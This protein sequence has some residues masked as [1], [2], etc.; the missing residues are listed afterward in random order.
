MSSRFYIYDI[1]TMLNC[2]LYAGKFV[3]D[4]TV[5]LFEISD[6]KN[7]R[8]ALLVHLSYLQNCGAVMVGY[9]S[10]TFDYRVVHDLLVNPYTF[11]AQ[12]AYNLAQEIIHSREGYGSQ[13]MRMS[14]RIIPQIDLMK[15]NHFDNASKRTSLKSLQF[16]MRSASVQDLPFPFNTPL[17]SEQMD[18][19][20]DY[21]VHDIT[22]TEEFFNK[23]KHL[24]DIRYELLNSGVLGGDVLNYSDVKL[25]VEYL[26]RKIGR[27]KCFVQGSTPR[28][29]PR[30][31]IEFKNVILPKI[32]YRTEEFE[33]VREWFKQQT[34]WLKSEERPRLETKLAGLDFHFGVGGVHAS[35]ENRR[36]VSN[37][38]HV[39][40][41]VDVSGMYVAVAISNGFYPEHLGRDFV[42]AYRQLQSDRAQ[43]PKGT[44]M[45]AV[46]KL[47]GNG[48]YGNSN[49]EWSCFYDPKYTFSV[50][51]NGQLQLI[52]LVEVLSL[53]PGL[54]V[55]QANTDGVTVYMPRKVEYLFNLWKAEWEKETALKLEEVEYSKMWIRDV[56]NYLV[57][58]ADGKIKAKGAYWYPKTIKDYD[59]AWNKD[60]SNMIC[61][62]AI[63]QHL[64]KGWPIEDIVRSACDPFDFMMRYKT[65]A[66]ADVYIG[67]QKMQKTVRYYVSK[68]GQPM[69]KIATPKGEI[70]TWKRRNGLTD[71]VYKKILAEIPKGA[72]DERI[73]TKNK[74]KYEQVTTSIESGRLIKEVNIASKFN[75][76]DVD[77]GYYIEEVKKLRIGAT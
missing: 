40:K 74:S 72:W 25:G 6:R 22:E 76:D 47:A 75:W 24:I 64:L 36:Y 17:T 58:T 8:D 55:I 73:H 46:L 49:N 38:T 53:I 71:A 23:C 13:P 31:S 1:E 29:T 18:I 65:P 20:R 54:E 70:G 45:N 27:Q 5:H 16:A 19:M 59:G 35:V 30:T 43:Y 14:D 3:G 60:F 2:F 61:Q 10:L 12:R 21:N 67:D 77:Y 37:D 26:T 56:N 69:K 11:T 9:N 15:V 62:K 51:V 63:E 66:G 7:E 39:I 42:Q 50:T 44:A 41:D 68:S 32:Y 52:Q 28:Q 34:I 48:V 33:S 4:P 57:L